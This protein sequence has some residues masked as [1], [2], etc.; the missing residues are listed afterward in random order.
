VNKYI[1]WILIACF[2]GILMYLGNSQ[3]HLK[4]LK[5]FLC[6]LIPMVFVLEMLF[7]LTRERK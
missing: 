6:I 1:E 5:V 2:V 7:R 3:F 4:H